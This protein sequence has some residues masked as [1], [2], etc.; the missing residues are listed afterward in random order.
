[1]SIYKCKLPKCT[2]EV[3]NEG[4]YCVAHTAIPVTVVVQ[5]KK[6]SGMYAMYSVSSGGAW[7]ESASIQNIDL[8]YHDNFKY[9]IITGWFTKV[10]PVKPPEPAPMR[11]C[12]AMGCEEVFTGTINLCEKH[13][14]IAI[15]PP[16]PVP[17]PVKPEKKHDNAVNKY[18]RE[19]IGLDGVRTNVDVYRVIDAYNVVN[20]QAQHAIKK[21]LAGGQRGYKSELQDLIE[22]RD[23]INSAI[24]LMG[25][26]NHG[27]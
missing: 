25:Q 22:C 10:E 17:V 16:V 7:R 27:K 19:I 23:S 2:V 6:G 11:H 8:N 12:V 24:V 18:I 9:D 21:L 26:K 15:T 14:N 4:V 13:R 1:M 20:P 3:C 5:Y